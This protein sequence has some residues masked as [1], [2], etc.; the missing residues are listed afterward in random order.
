MPNAIPKPTPR[1]NVEAT[2]A[3]TYTTISNRPETGSHQKVWHVPQHSEE[4]C[5]KVLTIRAGEEIQL[6]HAREA[7]NALTFS[8]TL[9][10]SSDAPT[11]C[12]YAAILTPT[13]SK[14]GYEQNDEGG[15][16]EFSKQ[17]TPHAFFRPRNGSG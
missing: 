12:K 16:S 2:A 5:A 10:Y 1:V 15:P 11:N 8:Q 3:K 9:L 17:T 14:N 6:P 7:C 13:L 4:H